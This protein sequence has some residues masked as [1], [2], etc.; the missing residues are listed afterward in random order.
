MDFSPF[1]GVVSCVYGGYVSSVSQVME[2]TLKNTPITMKTRVFIKGI[3]ELKKGR[4]GWNLDEFE[5]SFG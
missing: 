4:N 2:N 1:Y 3:F 5:F